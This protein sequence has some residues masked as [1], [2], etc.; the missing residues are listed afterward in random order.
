MGTTVG[1]SALRIRPFAAVA[2]DWRW[3]GK[4]ELDLH[5]KDRSREGPRELP[6]ARSRWIRSPVSDLRRLPLS[7]SGRA[8]PATCDWYPAAS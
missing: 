4:P 6:R 3:P 7:R 5:T 1:I 8:D 2:A